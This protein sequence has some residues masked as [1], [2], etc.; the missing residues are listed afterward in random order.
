MKYQSFAEALAEMMQEHNCL[1]A[2][3]RYVEAA[4][5]SMNICEYIEKILKFKE[6]NHNA[7]GYHDPSKGTPNDPHIVEESKRLEYQERLKLRRDE[8]AN[9]W[10]NPPKR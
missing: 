3:E 6:A 10:W 8:M 5:L 4:F 2:S 1:M 9:E 7:G